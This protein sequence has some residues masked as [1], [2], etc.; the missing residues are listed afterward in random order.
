MESLQDQIETLTKLMAA[1]E[2]P[3]EVK[4]EKMSTDE[5]LD[6]VYDFTSDEENPYSNPYNNYSNYGIKRNKS[7]IEKENQSQYIYGPPSLEENYLYRNGFVKTKQNKWESIPP[8]YIP[9]LFMNNPLDDILSIDCDLNPESKIQDW[10]NKIG[11]QIQLTDELKNLHPRDFL[12]YIM[13]KTQGNVYRFLSTLEEDDKSRLATT[14]ARETFKNV[15][16][17][18]LTEFIGKKLDDKESQE[19]FQARALWRITNLKICNMCYLDSFICEFSEHFY[20][21]NHNNQKTALEMFYQ[22]LPP[23]V[24]QEVNKL[25]QDSVNESQIADTLGAR[26]NILKTWLQSQCLQKQMT[27]EAN[28]N[29]CCE[30]LQDRIG[31]YG[32]TNKR[33]RRKK[34]WKKQPYKSKYKTY[35]KK[36]ERKYFRNRKQYKKKYKY[37]PNNK[38]KKDCKCWI[39]HEIGHYANECPK[40]GKKKEE[41]QILKIAY[42]L[43]YDPIEDSDVDSDIEIYG[44]TSAD[45]EYE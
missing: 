14:D 34:I 6:V 16:D 5:E 42:D 43:G 21:L 32:C 25:F 28:I 31:Q 41:T 29:L 1:L 38:P 8:Q 23:L 11:I 3:E 35:Y 27:K 45:D 24:S 18:I 19:A 39:C 33:K 36:G 15:L 10:S 7:Y 37:C 20:Y 12:N 30:K 44:Y 17:K 26:I 2:I 4:D 9:K 22:K 13:H 40:K